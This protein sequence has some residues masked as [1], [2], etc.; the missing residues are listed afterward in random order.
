[1]TSLPCFDGFTFYLIP[2]CL[3]KQKIA[4]N[5]QQLIRFS[6]RFLG[7]EPDSGPNTTGLGRHRVR[8][9]AANYNVSSS[10]ERHEIGHASL[11]TIVI[12]I[13]VVFKLLPRH[14]CPRSSLKVRRLVRDAVIT[15]VSRTS[16][17]LGLS[18]AL[19]GAS[20]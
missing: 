10:E 20:K 8:P 11:S 9:T 13:V 2:W 15:Q 16:R 14:S 1:M 12:T 4:R 6:P 7:T 3:Q 5:P 17:F 18:D 19:S